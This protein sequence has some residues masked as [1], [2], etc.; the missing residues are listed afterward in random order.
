MAK[1]KSTQQGIAVIFLET[2]FQRS[3]KTEESNYTPLQKHCFNNLSPKEQKKIREGYG[4]VIAD[5]ESESTICKFN[6]ENHHLPQ[7]AIE[8]YARLLLPQIQEFFSNEENRREFK[9][10]MENEKHRK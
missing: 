9:E 8:S 4:T 6:M 5:L 3:S 2:D 10:Y 1:R 7:S